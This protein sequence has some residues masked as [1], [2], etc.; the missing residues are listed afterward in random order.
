MYKHKLVDFVIHFM[1]EIDK[2]ISEMKLA[3]NA[4]ARVCAE[5]FLKRVRSAMIRCYASKPCS[6]L[7]MYFNF[8]L[9]LV[10]R[11]S[12]KKNVCLRWNAVYLRFKE[13]EK[14]KKKRLHHSSHRKPTTMK[15]LLR[16]Q[17]KKDVR[18][19]WKSIVIPLPLCCLKEENVR[20]W[21]ENIPINKN[22]RSANEN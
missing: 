6:P 10:L 11:W 7:W 22:N 13:S 14:L 18:E 21:K 20:K 12:E 4:R 19:R 17:N 2:E 8:V 1:E 16:I 5:E 3:V 9:Y 15:K